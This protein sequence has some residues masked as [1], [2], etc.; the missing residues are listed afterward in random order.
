MA[1]CRILCF[2]P[3][4]YAVAGCLAVFISTIAWHSQASWGQELR[5]PGATAS[6]N[7]GGLANESAMD[8]S[9]IL[10]LADESL[11]SLSQQPVLVPGMDVEVTTVSREEST[12][13]QPAAAI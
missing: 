4:P 5:A 9:D 2:K 1:G 12:V 7:E 8:P 11:E 13:G 3:Q 6:A 10:S